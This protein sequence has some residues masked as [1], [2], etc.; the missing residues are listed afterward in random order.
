MNIT[1]FWFWGVVTPMTKH[2][3]FFHEWAMFNFQTKI[4]KVDETN[5]GYACLVAGLVTFVY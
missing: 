5:L 3:T 4:L 1:L 2:I